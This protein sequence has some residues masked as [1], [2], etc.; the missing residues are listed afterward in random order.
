MHPRIRN[1]RQKELVHV[2]GSSVSSHWLTALVSGFGGGP[3]EL[4]SIDLFTVS[5]IIY[6]ENMHPR[7]L[8]RYH[9]CR[10]LSLLLPLLS[11]SLSLQLGG[12]SQWWGMGG[13]EETR[14]CFTLV[15]TT[16]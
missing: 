13:K 1:S 14:Y 6:S 10:H 5:P 12:S 2:S 7:A 11:S 3:Y 15:T 8:C 4:S 9:L 16:D